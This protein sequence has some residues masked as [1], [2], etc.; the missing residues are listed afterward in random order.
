MALQ[1]AMLAAKVGLDDSDLRSGVLRA[2]GLMGGLGR[3][4]QDV[5][6]QAVATA[7]GFIIRDVVVGSIRQ[8][9]QALTDLRREMIGA[10]REWEIFE[11][12]FYVQMGR[13]Y[14]LA[15]ER[16]QELE[17]FGMRT[18]FRLEEV[19]EADLVLQNFGLHAEDARRRWGYAGADIRRI[20]GDMAAGTRASIQEIAMWLGR[21]AA[22][23]TG[24][25]IMRM[26][27]L[28]IV[29][30]EQ[31]RSMGVEFSKAGALVSPVDEAFTAL[32]QLAEQ[33]FGGLSKIESETLLG[34]ES[35]LQDWMQRQKRLWGEPVFEAYSD[36]L[37]SLL[38]F[39]DTEA[40]QGMME[41][42]LNMWRNLVD[43]ARAGLGELGRLLSY[44]ALDLVA[45]GEALAISLAD[46]MA[47]PAA[48]NYIASALGSWGDTI[49]YWLESHSPP[50][51]LP[52]LDDWG[53]DAA[54]AWLGGWA[55]VSPEMKPALQDM[56]RSLE[57]FLRGIDATGEYDERVLGER[58]GPQTDLVH[59][60]V[61]SYQQL[62][63][64]ARG[65]TEAEQAHRDAVESGD[66]EAISSAEEKL[67]LAREEERQAQAAL[68]SA[69]RR[70]SQKVRAE[71][72]LARAISAQTR[73][74][75]A[76]TRASET[77][78][79]VD[80]DADARRQ[81]A[82]QERIRQ[83]RLQLE[84]T[85]AA[86]PGAQI[87]IWERELTAVT[88]GSVEYYTILTR[89]AAL[90]Q[91]IEAS[92]EREAQASARAAGSEAERLQQAR[93]RYELAQAATAGGQLE[94]W[95][96]EL[97]RVGQGTVE[98]YEIRI[99]MLEL[100]RRAAEEAATDSGRRAAQGILQRALPTRD[101][102]GDS[103]RQFDAETQDWLRAQEP[104]VPEDPPPGLLAAFWEFGK[105]A[106]GE[107]SRGL[108][109]ALRE[110]WAEWTAA[111][112]DWAADASTVR[113]AQEMGGRIGRVVGA[114]LTGGLREMLD[115]RAARNAEARQRAEA[116]WGA[117][118]DEE[119]ARAGGVFNS[120][121]ELIGEEE[122]TLADA[123]TEL[124]AVMASAFFDAFA[125]EWHKRGG[126]RGL[127]GISWNMPGGRE[128]W[129]EHDRQAPSRHATGARSFAGGW[130]LVGEAGPELVALPAGSRIYNHTETA[131]MQHGKTQPIT[132]NI[133]YP[134]SAKDAEIG[135]LRGLRAA[136][137]TP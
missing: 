57:P 30:R 94:I 44:E 48:M 99:R 74:I 111:M 88:V 16:L 93:L 121:E 64:A 78:A 13:S 75:E 90:R 36:G 72:E 126:W 122:P 46:G 118:E 115:Q 87:A 61:R 98:W 127:L 129:R 52:D 2:Q 113:G 10:N 109:D 77:R 14:D 63:Q 101:P 15:G 114:A 27:E 25:A 4:F 104:A 28:G 117:I 35:N 84:L 67:T 82:E 137:V 7:A 40:A 81:E 69:E 33:K 68:Q 76:Q 43:G 22:G 41:A 119:L 123:M 108:M 49:R 133:N 20:A 92:M 29:T 1:V 31:L 53:S 32:L 37:R 97:A 56:M 66:K 91:G 95:Q 103:A 96:R 17:E 39:L 9:A 79:H 51:L 86:T 124:A 6:R 26:Q 107:L 45:W 19:I 83:A 73:A 112:R 132:I 131:R 85:Q 5:G 71:M 102:L 8:T 54:R 21:F 136:G 128:A 65:V 11:A 120:I 18:P 42:G 59:D 70:I 134:H 58:F 55:E 105:A 24:Q 38:G 50:R 89:I 12:R 60:Y 135:V 34:M 130:S 47:S 80:S 23:D 106:A 116:Y 125:Q 3:S 110:K 62:S 100:E